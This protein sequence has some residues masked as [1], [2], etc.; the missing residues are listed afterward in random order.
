MCFEDEKNRLCKIIHWSKFRILNLNFCDLVCETERG[1][2]KI[3]KKRKRFTTRFV[4][5]DL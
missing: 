5:L 1:V 2:G 4:S 3:E